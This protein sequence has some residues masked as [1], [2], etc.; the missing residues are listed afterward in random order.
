MKL[1]KMILA[2]ILTVAVLL[3]AVFLFG[4]Y[5]WKLF[6]F[7]VCET[8]GIEQ[9]NVEEDHVRIRGFYPGSF[10][11]GFL[12]YHAEQVDNALYVGFKFSALFGIFETGDFDITIPARGEISQVYIKTSQSEYLIWSSVPETDPEE[13]AT[14]PEENVEVIPYSTKSLVCVHPESLPTILPAGETGILVRWTDSNAEKT[15][16]VVI[17]VQD[18]RVIASAQL[19]GDWT[20]LEETFSDGCF[21]LLNRDRKEWCFLTGALEPAGTFTVE[22]VTGFFSHDRKTYYSLQDH[23]LCGTDVSSGEVQRIALPYDLRFAEILAV[24]PSE[25]RLV[26]R[27]LLS[28]YQSTCGTVYLDL[29]TNTYILMT[30]AR[31]Q[32]GFR[33]DSPY[34]FLF[35]E[36]QMGYSVLYESGSGQYSRADASLFQGGSAE[37]LAVNGSAYLLGVGDETMLYTLSDT[38]SVCSLASYGIAGEFRSDCWL[39]ETQI[40]TG[41]VYQQG[42]FRLYTVQ[43]TALLFSEIAAAEP[44]E[45]PLTV[46]ARLWEAYWDELNGGPVANTLQD[47]REYADRLEEKYGVSI[48]FSA[49]CSDAAALCDIP[50]TTTDQM[51]FDN[52]AYQINRALVGLDRSLALHPE[53]FFFQFQNRMGEGGVRFLLV[54]FIDSGYGAIGVSFK[55]SAW[56][57][58]AID[59]RMDTFES[60]VCHEVWHAAEDKIVSVD[61][62]AFSRDVWAACN[63]EGFEYYGDASLTDP[64]QNMWT[65]FGTASE[66]VYFVDSY[67]RV[68]A[69]EDRARI[70]EYIMTKEEHAQELAQ[71]PAIYKKLS[72]MCEAVRENFDTTQ[73]EDVPW[74]RFLN[75]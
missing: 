46:N 19:E 6:G 50:I 45:S 74:E 3:I 25:D 39:P 58:I 24:H 5:S 10:P 33:N 26:L 37:L 17:D 14:G 22:D 64:D 27:F 75:K 70:M 54:G 31:Y 11:T 68:N 7:S 41:A 2:I 40:M 71:C 28:P 20:V 16:L 61:T 38:V 15:S 32:I 12:G 8:A 34:L 60:L 72:L 9:I 57:N 73:W 55:S 69:K 36:R 35:D 56:H 18:D 30:E 63:P 48:L 43:P 49:Q 23:I 62:D 1:L 29:T 42:A 4:R 53:N 59:V 13:E 67:S 21:A 65:F 44:V 66:E 52:E 47:A 51:D